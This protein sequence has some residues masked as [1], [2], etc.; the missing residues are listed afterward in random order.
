MPRATVKKTPPLH[1]ARG[2]SDATRAS[3]RVPLAMLDCRF[4]RRARACPSP[5]TGLSSKHPWPLGCGRFPQRWR[6]RGGQAPALRKKRHSLTVVRG[7]VPRQ[8]SCTRNP[9]LAGDRPP[10]YGEKNATPS[11]RARACPS[12]SFVHAQS[13]ARGG[14]APALREHRDRRSL[15]P[16]KRN[17]FCRGPLR[18]MSAARHNA[19]PPSDAHLPATATSPA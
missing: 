1:V 18:D 6:D 7:P 11:R 4:H 10:R 15:L 8:R 17:R 5:C 12:P 3:E 19:A 16:G 9:T 14:Q 13:N 2:P